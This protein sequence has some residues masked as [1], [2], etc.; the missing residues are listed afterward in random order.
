MCFIYQSLHYVTYN[1]CNKLKPIKRLK[2]IT[3]QMQISRKVN[4]ECQPKIVQRFC[5]S[6][7]L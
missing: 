1:A 2:Y 7:V 5:L 4:T 6:S 3:I